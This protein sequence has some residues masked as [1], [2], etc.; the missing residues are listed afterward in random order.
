MRILFT[1]LITI[2]AV[3]GLKAQEE[4]LDDSPNRPSLL[5]NDFAYPRFMNGE[6]HSSFYL[7]Y[8]LSPKSQIELQAYFD[9]YLFS[10][11]FRNSLTFKRYLTDKFYLFA[12]VEI[13]A[14]FVKT[15]LVMKRPPRVGVI[16]GFGYDVNRNFTMEAKSNIGINQSSMGVFGE[17]VIPMPQVYTIGGKIKF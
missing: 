9:T 13:E 3:F 6:E 5:F 14:E 2:L 11:R 17:A 10:N 12:G 1:I 4:I 15:N 16:S 8:Q 7:N